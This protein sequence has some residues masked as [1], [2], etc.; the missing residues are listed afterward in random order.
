M[1]DRDYAGGSRNVTF[2]S[3]STNNDIG[4]GCLTVTIVDK[5]AVDRDKTFTVTLTTANNGV[6][7]RNSLTT[8]TIMDDE[9]V[10]WVVFDA[11]QFSV[12]L[13]FNEIIIMWI[14]VATIGLRKA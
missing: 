1:S 14:A 13:H 8:I 6:M 9:G 11:H 5:T 2:P 3:G 10:S 4:S 7:L 12:T